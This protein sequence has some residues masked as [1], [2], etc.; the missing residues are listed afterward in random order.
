MVNYIYENSG[1]TSHYPVK[2]VTSRFVSPWDTS[3]WYSVLPDFGTGSPVYSNT[4]VTVSECPAQLEGSEY[5]MTFNSFAAGFDDKQEVDFYVEQNSVVAVCIDRKIG[6]FP[7]FTNDFEHKDYA[8]KL[9]DGTVYDVFEK[10]FL[11]GDQVHIPGIKGDCNHFFV[12]ARAAKPEDTTPTFEPV[13][14]SAKEPATYEKRTY[15]YYV[16][17]VFNAKESLQNYSTEGHVT[18]HDETDEK[19]ACIDGTG[20]ISVKLS[21]TDV[22]FRATVKPMFSYGKYV[23]CSFIGETGENIASIFINEGK[24]TAV[25]NRMTKFIQ[26]A[27]YGQWYS[28]EVRYDSEARKAYFTVNSVACGIELKAT[29]KVCEAGFYTNKGQ[30]LIDDFKI[31]DNTE[32]YIADETGNTLSAHSF[33]LGK[34]AKVKNI[35]VPFKDRASAVLGSTDFLDASAHYAFSSVSETGTV[36]VKVKASDRGMCRLSLM[37]DIGEAGAVALYMNNLYVSDGT[38]WKRIYAG[39]TDWMYY[40]SKNWFMVKFVFDIG[41][42]TYDVWVD[43]A[44]RAKDFALVQCMDIRGIGFTTSCETELLIGKIRVYDAKSL[45]RNLLPAGKIFDVKEYGALG[46]GVTLDT[47]KIQKALDDAEGTGGVVL[48]HGGTFYSGEL[49]LRSDETLFVS[50]DARI[51]GTTDHSQYPLKEP[52]SSLCAHRQLGRGLIYGEDVK[53]VT[54]TGGGMLDGNGRYRYKMNDPHEHRR[55]EDARPD[56]I[57]ITYSRNIDIHDINFKS[58]AFWTVV[59]LSC[60]NVLIKNL[61]LDCMNTP[62]RD[63]IDPVDCHDITVSGCCIMAGDDGLCFKSSDPVGC[64]HIDVH[65]NM[66]QSLASG[67][68]FGTDTYYSL[69]DAVFSDCTV[70]NVQRCGVSLET[71]DGALVR[72]VSFLRI[73]MAD[74]SA[75]IYVSVGCRNRLPRGITEIRNSRME[76][77]VFRGIRFEDAYPFSYSKEIRESIICGQNISQCI[78]GITLDDWHL[79]LC[80]GSTEVPGALKTIDNKYPEYDRHGLSGGYA[81]AF[82]YCRNIRFGKIKVILKNPDVR[83]MASYHDCY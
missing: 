23:L 68:K 43:G 49:E 11:D 77:V 81:F 42:G 80:G 19:Y 22:I 75:P 33:T 50:E 34:N 30:L 1:N 28:F 10:G 31:F 41:A 29:G 40:P 64:Y 65:D 67:I 79:E 66:I 4:D 26:S 14:L 27:E 24:I 60:G 45:A 52:R 12:L 9:T 58:S 69:E 72:N 56:I 71:V 76:N 83:P 47:D 20:N 39:L 25:T 78:D 51:L 62:N 15:T 32:K 6:T 55:H 74:V 46:D 7:E 37:G 73:D 53:N 17:E 2:P 63:G 5:I 21:G 18:L 38:V 59:P 54:V 44:C 3:G 70:K 36:E 13:P 16:N 8:V 61:N 82:R 57:Y 48:V 35:P